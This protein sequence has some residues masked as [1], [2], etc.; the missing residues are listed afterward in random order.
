MEVERYG[1][2]S[3]GTPRCC[4]ATKLT[5]PTNGYGRTRSWLLYNGSGEKDVSHVDC[6]CAFGPESKMTSLVSSFSLNFVMTFIDALLRASAKRSALEL[7]LD[8]EGRDCISTKR[9]SQEFG[10]VL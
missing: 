10:F 4:K 1:V 8:T 2:H 7:I 6:F 3:V 9:K 5:T